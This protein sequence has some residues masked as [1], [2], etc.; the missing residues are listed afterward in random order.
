M[1]WLP[2]KKELK[3]KKYHNNSGQ[4]VQNMIKA[5]VYFFDVII[6]IVVLCDLG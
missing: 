4:P 5:K 3:E 6:E 2:R 1:P